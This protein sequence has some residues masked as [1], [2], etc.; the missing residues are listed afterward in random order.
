MSEKSLRGEMK[1]SDGSS[2][3]EGNVSEE[4]IALRFRLTGKQSE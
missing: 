1:V 3:G 4:G 2:A